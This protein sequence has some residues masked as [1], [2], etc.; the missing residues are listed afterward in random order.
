MRWD[1]IGTVAALGF[2]LTPVGAHAAPLSLEDAIRGAWA[3]NPGLAAGEDLVRAAREDAA[4]ARDARLPTLSFSAKG[5]VTDEPMMAF[6]IKLNE[7]KITEAD[8]TPARL[9]A[10]DPVGGVGLGASVVQPIYVGG[11]ITAGRR[12]AEAQAGAEARSQERRRDE[13]ALRVVDAYFGAQVADQGLR[14]AEDALQ[15][16]IETERFVRSRNQQGLALEAD[17]ARATAFRAQAEADRA[18]ARQRVASARSALVLLAGDEVADAELSTPVEHAPTGAP[19]SGAAP[20]AAPSA[21]S[22][23]DASDRR[24]RRLQSGGSAPTPPPPGERF[25]ASER[26]DLVAARLRATAA[27]EARTA[28]RGSLLPEVFAQAGVETLRSS[29]DQGATWF[30]GLLVARWQLSLGALDGTRAAEARAAAAHSA[31]AWQERQARR[32]VDEARRAVETA[33]VR[34]GSAR[35]AVA[36]SEAARRLREAR[37]R[38]GLLPLTDV[39]DAEAGLAGARSLLLG[40][41]HQARLARAQ[42]QLALGQPIEGVKS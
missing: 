29:I 36:A 30:Q 1:V 37:H 23:A 24:L 40:S 38:Q 42:L 10:P 35:E 22:L 11:R 7:Q 34:V 21:L 14:F 12:A 25:D 32:E 31:A 16:A 17:L 2:A 4:A 13:I 41:Q 26:S 5:I 18:T 8:F 27:D 9:N 33:D 6:G 28:A 3:R 20:A 39:L 19:R 15:H